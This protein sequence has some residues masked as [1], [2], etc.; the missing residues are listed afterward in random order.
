MK[1]TITIIGLLLSMTVIFVSCNSNSTDKKTEKT[2]SSTA[3]SD[4]DKNNT[5]SSKEKTDSA[6]SKAALPLVKAKAP[7]DKFKDWGSKPAETADGPPEPWTL[8]H[9]MCDA[10]SRDKIKSSSSLAPK[11]GK[12]YAASNVCDDDP[13]TAWVEGNAD[14]GIGEY[15]DIDM[16]PMGTG[17][18]S[19]L[20][21][22][23]SSKS[24]WENNSRV[25]KMK[26]S[27]DG[28]DHC[29][30]ELADV[31]GVQQFTIPNKDRLS[32]KAGNIIRFTILEVYPGAKYKDTAIS[33]I[34]SCG[35]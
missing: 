33:G 22:Y 18:I 34:F 29:T 35:G 8:T 26:V 11:G 20:N 7:T 15:L 9:M 5:I 12:T 10:P 17:E 2:A 30:I 23:Q 32:Y 21:G 27:I 4:N 24:T 25:K 13:S 31:M 14:H 3:K 16:V 1:N 6:D 19:I 28:K